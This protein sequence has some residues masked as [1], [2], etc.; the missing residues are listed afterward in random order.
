MVVIAFRF[1]DAPLQQTKFFLSQFKYIRASEN[2]KSNQKVQ[3]SANK[4]Y[5]LASKRKT[6]LQTT[7]K[8]A[9]VFALFFEGATHLQSKS[10]HITDFYTLS[11][12]LKN[13]TLQQEF[14]ISVLDKKRC[15]RFWFFYPA[16]KFETLAEKPRLRLKKNRIPSQKCA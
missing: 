13:Q 9:V 14:Q 1:S 15:Y 6:L 2:H 4:N 10:L 8:K 16:P 3:C 11:G 5:T 7:I 12:T